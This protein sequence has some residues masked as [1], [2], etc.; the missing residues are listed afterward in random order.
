MTNFV[1]IDTDATYEGLTCREM[2]RLARV[3]LGVGRDDVNRYSDVDVVQALN[4]G[5]ERFAKLTNCLMYPV[6][7]IGKAGRQNYPLPRGTLRVLSA[8]WYTGDTASDYFDLQI[9]R[10]AEDMQ[11]RD[12]MYRGT[13]GDPNFMFPTYRSGN[14]LMVGV[15]PIPSFDGNV[16]VN[17]VP[18]GKDTDI[19]GFTIAGNISGEHKTG[20]AASAFLVDSLGRDLLSLG[21]LPGYPVYNTTQGT[22]GLITSIENGDTVNDK[23]V[24][25]LSGS[26]SWAVGDSYQILMANYGI[27]LDADVDHAL[28]G[29]QLGVIADVITGVGTFGLDVA[30]KPIPL[31]VTQDTMISEIPSSYQEAQVSYAVYWLASG[32]FAGVS[33]PK[34]AADAMAIFQ[35]YVNEFNLSDET[36]EVSENMVDYHEWV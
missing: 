6:V 25:T 3:R 26:G 17:N 32:Q 7:I 18:Y 29:S 34:K 15:S 35:A 16:I 21:A 5:Q 20:Y 24:A 23:V 13:I 4:M 36:L 33:Q 8:R 27:S 30:R 31:S 9:L 11:K 19:T 22:S 28:I 14:M 1:Q 12:S 10:T 2:I